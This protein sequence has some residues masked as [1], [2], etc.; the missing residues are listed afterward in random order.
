ML[1]QS[2]FGVLILACSVLLGV[3]SGDAGDLGRPAAALQAGVVEGGPGACDGA[4]CTSDELSCVE[5]CDQRLTECTGRCIDET[6]QCLCE[7][8]Y[9]VCLDGCGEPGPG[10]SLCP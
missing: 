7:N 9:S 8:K 2:M 5:R 10:L 3:R 4:T 1:G 6:C